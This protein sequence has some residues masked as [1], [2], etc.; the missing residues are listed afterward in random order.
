MRCELHSA[1]AAAATA[2]VLCVAGFSVVTFAL[3]AGQPIH[4]YPSLAVTRVNTSAGNFGRAAAIV[5]ALGYSV[6][7]RNGV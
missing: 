2:L 7:F 1:P 5:L 3:L 4:V 6:L